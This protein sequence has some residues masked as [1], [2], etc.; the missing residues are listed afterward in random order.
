VLG[1]VKRAVDADPR[2]GRYI[3]TGSVR[4]ELEGAVVGADTKT[5]LLDS[6][7]LGRLI[8]TF[9]AAQLRAE[10]PLSE[11]RPRMYH[12]RQDGGRREIDVLTEL[13]AHRVIAIEIK[14]SGNPIPASDTSPGCATSWATHSSTVCVCT[15]AG[16]S[17]SSTTASPPLPFARSGD[18]QLSRAGLRYAK[19]QS[20]QGGLTWAFLSGF[21]VVRR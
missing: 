5:V 21:W 8:D 11:H 1:A 2:P 19:A 12:L 10:F 13:S 6:N 18:E 14:A 3:L 4:A 15:Q 20:R 17:S 7:L 16:S 9:V